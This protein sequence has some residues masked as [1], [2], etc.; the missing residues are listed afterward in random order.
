MRLDIVEPNR[1][2]ACVVAESSLFERINAP[3]Y[4]DPH[5]LVI[6]GLVLQDGA[7]KVD[8]GEDGVL[9]L[10]GQICVR[11]VDGLR[12]LILEEALMSH[13]SCTFNTHFIDF[14]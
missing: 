8:I 1:A 2:L 4:D 12:E 3:Q 9:L 6:K 10:Q 11:N 5:L 14:S 13:R 7:K